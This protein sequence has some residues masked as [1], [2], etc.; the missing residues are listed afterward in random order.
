MHCNIS[1]CDNEAT[2]KTSLTDSVDGD[3]RKFYL[4]IFC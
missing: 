1:E 4:D 3:T 2:R